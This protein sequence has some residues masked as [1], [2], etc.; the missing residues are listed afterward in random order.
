MPVRKR[1]P[2]GL[3]VFNLAFLLIVLKWHHSNSVQKSETKMTAS[4]VK[5][6]Q[7]HKRF[8]RT[9]FIRTR[10]NV[11]IFLRNSVLFNFSCVLIMF[12][13]FRRR[14]NSQVTPALS[15]PEW[16]GWVVLC[17]MKR[18]WHSGVWSSSDVIALCRVDTE[19]KARPPCTLSWGRLQR[20]L[21]RCHSPCCR[22]RVSG[23]ASLWPGAINQHLRYRLLSGQS[24]LPLSW[25]PLLKALLKALGCAYG[26]VGHTELELSG[27]AW[28]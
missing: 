3:R 21:S 8:K 16:R 15:K 28:H 26:R 4:V 22:I 9:L 11:L 27:W 23:G 2:K 7:T 24:P 19:L 17:A 18:Q 20:Q 25:W 1:K 6:I 13:T 14:R 12:C 10:Y 5:Q